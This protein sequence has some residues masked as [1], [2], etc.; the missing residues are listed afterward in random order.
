MSRH[1][2]ISR[3]C[4]TGIATV[5]VGWSSPSIPTAQAQVQTAQS[6]EAGTPLDVS[7]STRPSGFRFA[8]NPGYDSNRFQLLIP[9][10]NW[11]ATTLVQLTAPSAGTIE[12]LDPAFDTLVPKGAV[13]EHLA[14][15]FGFT[16][17]PVWVQGD[18]PFLLFSDIPGNR[19]IK[20]TPIGIVSDF[21]APVFEGAPVE[22]RFSG[23]NGITVAPNGDI[24]FT[25]HFNGRISRIT[26]DGTRSIVIDNFEGGRLNSPNDLAYKSDG[27]LYFTDPPYGLPTPED[28]ALD[29][30]GIYRLDPDGTLT[31]L[32]EQPGPNGI[33]F[34]PDEAHLYVADSS[35]NRWMRYD[36]AADGSLGAGDVLLDASGVDAPGAAD[37]LKVDDEGN[38]WAT[39]PGG[40]WVISAEGQHLGTIKPTE[41][42]ANVAWGD[43][44]RTL[45]MT[46]RTGLYRIRVNASGPI[47]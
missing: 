18:D 14:D 46:G 40:V 3:V 8:E 27:S 5:C 12:R 7:F 15:G 32:A 31:R 33:A 10:N 38:L 42:P 23:S 17:G 1:Q 36:V 9:T 22:D 34:S 21:L 19:I 28:R 45:Y 47:P 2:Y 43:D 24:V 41:V 4:T 11:N 16:E 37:G 44:G 13:I 20:W 25:E 39:G 30:N 29:V 35:A 6:L 26:A